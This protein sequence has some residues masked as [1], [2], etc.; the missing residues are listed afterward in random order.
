MPV[1]LIRKSLLAGLG[2][3]LAALCLLWW[4]SLSAYPLIMAPF[5]ASCVILFALPESPLAQ[6]RNVIGGHILTALVGLLALHFLPPS[7]WATALAVGVGIAAM[8]VTKTTH[9]P[10]G[11]NPLLILLAGKSF[12]WSFLLFP[13]GIGA[14][15]LVVMAAAFHAAVRQLKYPASQL[16]KTN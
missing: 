5:G 4:S 15:L 12:A 11:A 9:P 7:I 10:A 1:D 3:G 6:P 2:G 16:K 14:L 13:V 8:V